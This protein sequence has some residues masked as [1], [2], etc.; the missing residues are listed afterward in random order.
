[1]KT[2]PD[3]NVMD[4]RSVGFEID[5]IYVNLRTIQ[6]ILSTVSGVNNI[7]RRRPFTKWESVHIWFKYLNH[8]FIVV[9][10]FG[11][12]SRYW[13][14]PQNPEEKINIDPI[15]EVFDKYQP[16][17]FRKIIG[18]VATLN[19]SSLFRRA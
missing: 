2:Y 6:L 12:N 19:F 17:V 7:K 10:P 18:D 1:M 13:I 15:K 14:G 8:N 4:D 3:G 9:E 5:N 16:P 11:D